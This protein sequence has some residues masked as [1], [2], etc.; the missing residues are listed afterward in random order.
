M[1]R[2]TL[3]MALAVLAGAGAARADDTD[4]GYGHG[5]L[6]IGAGVSNNKVDNI[7]H[8]GVSFGDIDKTSWKVFAGVRPLRFLGIEA[9]YLDLGNHTQSII[10]G[11][12]SADA[13]AFAGY[14]VLFL[15]LPVPWLDIYGKAGAA[16]W[17]L[18]TNAGAAGNPPSGS[19]FDI[20]DR[21]TEF[22]WGLGAQAHMGMLGGR[23]EYERFDIP[24]TNGAEVFSL[25]LV[26]S[27][28]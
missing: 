4:Y 21:G 20:S 19:L 1:R 6:Y 10:A 28:L 16:R 9:D 26:L 13:K 25:S 23:L 11:T 22:A 27:F 15:P 17:E 7:T 2:F 8:T 14:G 24:H 5:L 3:L 12:T 18:N